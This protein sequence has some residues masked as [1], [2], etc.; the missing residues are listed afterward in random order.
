MTN[1]HQT[2]VRGLILIGSTSFG[3]L[4]FAG[5]HKWEERESVHRTQKNAQKI[6]LCVTLTRRS[7]LLSLQQWF[8]QHIPLTP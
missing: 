4:W 5:T 7:P 8:M 1:N 3:E 2:W 6:T